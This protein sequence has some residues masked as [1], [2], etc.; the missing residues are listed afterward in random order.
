MGAA[1]P[2]HGQGADAAASTARPAGMEIELKL[3]VPDA[4]AL[5]AVA[6]AAAGVRHPPVFQ[7]NHFFDAAARPLRAASFGMRLREEDGLFWLTAKGRMAAGGHG[8]P[9]A[10][11]QRREE[12]AEVPAATAHAILSGACCPLASLRALLPSEG[13]ALLDAIDHARGDGPLALLGSFT[14]ER[15]R[16][17]TALAA[18]GQTGPAHLELDRSYFPGDREECEVEWELSASV[19]SAWAEAALLALLERAGTQGRVVPG[20]AARFFAYLDAT[21]AG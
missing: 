2:D 21:R 17:D 15:T 9:A 5:E 13:H 8:L 6:R 10:L 14:N 3:A 1:Q 16:V 19:D 11:A 20:K 7:R 4:A 12:E 18:L